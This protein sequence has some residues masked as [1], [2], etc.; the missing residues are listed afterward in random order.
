[1]SLIADLMKE[2][3]QAIAHAAPS[4]HV[5]TDAATIRP[6]LAA[7]KPLAWVGAP[8]SLTLEATGSGVASFQIALISPAAANHPQGLD[9]LAE[10]ALTLEPILGITRLVPDTAT[11]GS[12]PTYPALFCHFETLYQTQE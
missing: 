6:T 7:G 2:I 3:T 10:I 5:T 4:L 11:P 1:M 9:D 12:G 8:E